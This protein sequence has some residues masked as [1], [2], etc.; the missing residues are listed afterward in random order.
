MDTSK[1]IPNA[2]FVCPFK[3]WVEKKLSTASSPPPTSMYVPSYILVN[4]L[5]LVKQKTL[6]RNTVCWFVVLFSPNWIILAA[7]ASGSASVENCTGPAAAAAG[8]P[9]PLNVL[10]ARWWPLAV[11]TSTDLRYVPQ[12]MRLRQTDAH[13]VSVVSTVPRG[14]EQRE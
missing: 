4:T 14:G 7:S 13:G 5:I 1:I 12:L 6:I 3:L 10:L 8:K 9:A 2:V 11:T